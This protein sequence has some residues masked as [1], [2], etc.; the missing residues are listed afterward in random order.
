MIILTSAFLHSL[1]VRLW[2]FEKRVF[3]T[4]SEIDQDDQ[5]DD[6]GLGSS[7]FVLV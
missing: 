1:Q 3:L 4:G 6:L 2:A 5:R 7:Y